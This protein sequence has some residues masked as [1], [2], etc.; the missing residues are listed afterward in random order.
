MKK[1]CC[2]TNFSLSQQQVRLEASHHS[3]FTL[4]FSDLKLKKAKNTYTPTH[5]HTQSYTHVFVWALIKG[6]RGEEVGSGV[7]LLLE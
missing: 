7:C 6:L 4:G 2:V 1:S 5:P 3:L